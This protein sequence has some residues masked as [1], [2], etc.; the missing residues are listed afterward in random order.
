MRTIGS[1]GSEVRKLAGAPVEWR[2]PG[3][4]ARFEEAAAEPKGGGGRRWWWLW[5]RHGR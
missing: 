3:S 1:G 5:R 4:A 2:K